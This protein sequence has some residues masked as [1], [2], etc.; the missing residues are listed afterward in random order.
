[1]CIGLLMPCFVWFELG[2]SCRWAVMLDFG[3]PHGDENDHPNLNLI[4]YTYHHGAFF[5]LGIR[6]G[7][8]MGI[9]PVLFLRYILSVSKYYWLPHRIVPK[10]KWEMGQLNE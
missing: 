10:Q 6:C 4:A 5:G 2:L 7:Q 9:S 1:M 8:E 3:N